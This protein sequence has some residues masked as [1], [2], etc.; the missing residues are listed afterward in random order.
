MTIDFFVHPESN[1]S[2]YCCHSESRKKVYREYLSHLME[3]VSGS[4][5]PVL[6]K[7]FH[8]A[9]QT[10]KLKIPVSNHFESNDCGEIVS[11]E[12]WGKLLKLIGDCD[13]LRIHGSYFGQCTTNLA[14]QLLIHLKK[15]DDVQLLYLG[16][17]TRGGMIDVASDYLQT[18]GEFVK[19]KIRY[20][21]VFHPSSKIEINSPGFSNFFRKFPCGNVNFQLIDKSTRIYGMSE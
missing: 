1:K 10:F 17:V 7:D 18:E 14:Q 5:L 13:D 3:I 15:H 16:E 8:P 4:E 20:G 2:N 19:S 11:K 9:R 6:I 21:V 12:E